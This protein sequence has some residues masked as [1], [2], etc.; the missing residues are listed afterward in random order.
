[1]L[2][3]RDMMTTNVRTLREDDTLTSAD[4]DMVVAEVHHLPVV[5]RFNRVVGMISD[6]EVLRAGSL[7]GVSIARVM[8]R[9][10]ST[11]LPSTPALEAAVQLLQSHQTALPVVDATG[12]LLGIVTTTDF[13]ELAH[14]ALAG[15]DVQ[16]PHTRA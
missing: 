11:A 1:M 6:R 15:L 7:G 4:W 12:V 13:V 5:D 16:R 3:L 14:R 10:F 2:Q 9:E 8:D